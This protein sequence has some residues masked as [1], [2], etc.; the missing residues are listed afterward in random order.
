MNKLNNLKLLLL[1]FV[2]II[3][4]INSCTS[5]VAQIIPDNT[6]PSN[7][8][9]IP[10]GQILI[11]EGGTTRTQNLF[12]SFQEF[13]LPRGNTALFNNAPNIENIFSRVTGTSVSNL[14]GL[15]LSNGSA[16]LFFIN[17][18]GIIFGPNTI[19][20]VGGSFVAT[21]A[22]SIRFSDGSEY[23][24]I[25]SQPSLLTNHTPI[26]LDFSKNPGL[27]IVKGP[28]YRITEIPPISPFIIEP[29]R[30]GLIAKP[31][32]T[33]AL[34]GGNINIEGGFI[35]APSGRIE[36]G[37]VQEGTVNF[38]IDP[39]GW[40]FDYTHANSWQDIH[41]TNLAL[42]STSG[43]V[44]GSIQLQGKN[45]TIDGGGFVLILNLG[46]LPSGNVVVKARETLLL[47]EDVVKSD[48]SSSFAVGRSTITTEAIGSGK[49][50]NIIISS[51]NLI[52][53]QGAV[54]GT[55]GFGNAPSGEINIQVNQ[56]ILLLDPS[57]INPRF[58]SGISA[59]T[60]GTGNAGTINI[61]A[62]NLFARNGGS[63]SSVTFSEGRS[64]NFILNIEDTIELT[65]VLPELFIA[66]GIST[67]SFGTGAGGTLTINTRKLLVRDGARVD[68]SAFASGEGGNIIINASKLIEVS[69][70]REDVINPAAI[71][72]AVD[73][74][75]PE[76]QQALN[77]PAIPQGTSGNISLNT[78][79]L[80]IKNGGI[81]AVRNVG[82]GNA[83]NISINSPEI[84]VDTNG[85]ITALTT[86]GEGGNI[87]FNSS[88]LNLNHNASIT[89]TAGA[90]GNGGNISLQADTILL[91]NGSA[92]TA[93]AFEGNG[94]N[95]LI[96]AQVLI[97]SPDSQITASSTLGVDGI[98][99]INTPGEELQSI[100][101][102]F[103]VT[104]VIPPNVL[105]GSCLSSNRVNYQ[106][107]KVT[108]QNQLPVTPETGLSATEP[109]SMQISSE[110]DE[111]LESIPL[112]LIFDQPWPWQ[113]GTGLPILSANK[114]V[115]LPD[116]RV[117]SALESPVTPQQLENLLCH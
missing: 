7:S 81:I 33:I 14:D 17:P 18:N 57:L 53:D 15:L 41:I 88:H 48:L 103:N 52:I 72:S 10:N 74:V 47:A 111:N 66:T 69:G 97:A 84:I 65:G 4:W 76:I 113:P 9:V 6:L 112:Q 43:L 51:Q 44:G 104:L 92:I 58:F 70:Q 8:I 90:T 12:H 11:I 16:N 94:G 59:L 27:I 39:R 114:I 117:V 60:G 116:G 49:A 71:G 68:T 61:S 62:T 96:N 50:G 38:N 85:E 83:G 82:L 21:T 91:R 93:N 26:G 13:S 5:G 40:N 28:G 37:A 32:Q 31:E 35:I 45:I 101:T 105:D 87:L 56:D 30:S 95:I 77:L 64:G 63:L 107:L 3:S 100:L 29:P 22:S 24:A 99:E 106:S 1:L 73:V 20:N 46:E 78:P 108:E 2:N 102:P 23:S 55:R 98:V 86:S 67:G 75:D 54:I 42:V 34:I 110:V 80:V 115:E 19:V 36:L 109:V 25:P 89:S 79:R